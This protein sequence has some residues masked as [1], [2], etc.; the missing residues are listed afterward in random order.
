MKI[1]HLL[2]RPGVARLRVA[3]L[4]FSLLASLAMVACGGGGGGPTPTPTPVPEAVVSKVEN[5]Q[6]LEG[7]TQ[8]SLLEFVVTLDKPAVGA[9]T[10]TYSTSAIAKTTGYATSGGACG[11]AVDFI[12]VTNQSITINRGETTGKL[13]VTVCADTVFEPNETLDLTWTSSGTSGGTVQGVIVNDDAG[14]V[15]STGSTSMLPG[16]VAFGRDV[17]VLTN[18]STDGALGFAF[19]NTA[20][21]VKDK[22]TGLTW[23]P[24]PGVTRAYSDLAT[25]VTTINQQALCTFTDWRV[26]TANELANLMDISKTKG[27][28]ANADFA[29][30]AANAMTG[31]FWS[32]DVTKASPT[33]NAWQVA[34]DSNGVISFDKQTN[35]KNVRLVSGGSSASAACDGTDSLF[36]KL[37]EGTVTDA[38]TGLMWKQCPEGYSDSTSATGCTEGTVKTFTSAASVVTQLGLANSAADKGYADWRV[39]TRN[40][41]ATLVNRA[42]T[43]PAINSSFFPKN[44]SLA[45]I[46][47]SLDANAPTTQVW[48]VDF[49]DGDVRPNFLTRSYILRLVRAG[50]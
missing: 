17:N 15:N 10:V 43:N 9:V 4:G 24:L 41:L 11:G 47:A 38:R 45:Y 13:T 46:T 48:S 21:C 20:P 27:S 49:A 33:A 28:T 30:D 40:E 2:N 1:T 34:A 42:C 18:V 8:A 12:A 19:V 7:D 16:L 39:P 5:P 23:Q 35:L 44:E 37:A 36:T 31:P 14:G 32:S 29:L 26:P 25:Y 6:V 50:Q 22:V 3:S